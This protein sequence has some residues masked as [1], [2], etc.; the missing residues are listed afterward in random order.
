MFPGPWVMFCYD[1]PFREQSWGCANWMTAAN[2]STLSFRR[3]DI[4]LPR[5]CP[6]LLGRVAHLATAIHAPRS[7]RHL[8]ITSVFLR[9][10]R[11][12]PAAARLFSVSWLGLL[13]GRSWAFPLPLSDP[14]RCRLP[15]DVLSQVQ[16]EPIKLA[17]C[18]L[19]EILGSSAV[20]S[21]EMRC[22]LRHS[23]AKGRWIP[24]SSPCRI[25]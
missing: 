24:T 5:F 7:R 25:L 1:L 22:R 19:V 9:A 15:V 4:S 2:K 10:S 16:G 11:F 23:Q 18:D 14:G 20:S 3:K 12:E 13:L 8:M 17:I 21:K 6:H